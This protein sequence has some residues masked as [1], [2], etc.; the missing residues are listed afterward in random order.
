M[1]FRELL[2]EAVSHLK[3][4]GVEDPRFDARAILLETFQMDSA[5]F[6]LQENQDLREVIPAEMLS[7]KLSLFRNRIG[8][9]SVREPLQQILGHC[10][11]YGLDFVVT[12]SVLCPRMDTEVLVDRAIA[13]FRKRDQRLVMLDLCTGSGC[14]GISLARNLPVSAGLCTDISDEALDVAEKNAQRL[15][16]DRYRIQRG[17]VD[18]GILNGDHLEQ[19]EKVR[20]AAVSEDRKSAL[21]ELRF[22][23][24]DL[25]ENVPSLLSEWH[26][27]GFD[28]IVSNPPYIRSDVIEGL[29]PEVRDHEPR[30]ALD[31]RD[32]GLYFYR[33]IANQTG[34]F[35][36][37]GG[38]LY[39]EI[40]YDQGQDVKKILENAG[41]T[42]VEILKDLS[43]LDRVVTTRV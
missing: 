41:F 39:L 4:G 37:P 35:L 8:R 6:L 34:A 24:S 19:A 5:H 15:L 36:A 10:G 40:G 30:I 21:P 12:D 42:G 17:F 26:L 18:Q 20:D 29:E 43:G 33:K 13:D 38:S 32:D 25:Y 1:T 14:I 9:R 2:D 3:S 28:L 11:F 16:K 31:G 22:L 27:S 23:K 7:A